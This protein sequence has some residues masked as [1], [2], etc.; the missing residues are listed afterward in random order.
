MVLETDRLILRDFVLEDMADVH[1]YA[2]DEV[3]ATYM[4]WGPN[5]EDETRAFIGLTIQMQ[6]QE[7]RVDYELAVVLKESGKLI[8]GC[9]LRVT[10]PL[11]GEIGYC[12]NP[13]YWRQGYASEAAAA[14]LRYGFEK[15]GLH[16][17]YATCRPDNVGSASVMRKIGMRYEGHLREHMRYK[18]KWH[19]SYVH[20]ILED[21]WRAIACKP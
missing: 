4:I 20:A 3:V 5:T 10:E 16:R 7:P 2:S 12:F 19:D 13:S 17:V 15:H 1:A 8:G 6:Q 18:D 11:T 14:M 9:G 21:E